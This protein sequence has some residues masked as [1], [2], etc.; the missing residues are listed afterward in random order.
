ML[1]ECKHA[2]K[3]NKSPGL[4]GLFNMTKS[5]ENVCHFYIPSYQ[6]IM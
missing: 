5:V 4:D 3:T 2:L 1:E 6:V